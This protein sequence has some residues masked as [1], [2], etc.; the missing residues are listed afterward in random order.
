[1]Q[2]KL[3][4]YIYNAIKIEFDRK[5]KGSVSFT[6]IRFFSLNIESCCCKDTKADKIWWS[7]LLSFVFVFQNRTAYRMH[8]WGVTPSLACIISQQTFAVNCSCYIHFS[9]VKLTSVLSHP[10]MKQKHIVLLHSFHRKVTP[11]LFKITFLC[12]HWKVKSTKK[13]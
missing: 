11:M 2:H 5:I 12:F 9:H 13:T 7:L 10:H 8:T 4:T 1:M 6:F 3:V